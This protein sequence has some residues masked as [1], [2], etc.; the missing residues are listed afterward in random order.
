[1]ESFFKPGNMAEKEGRA[2]LARWANTLCSQGMR[3]QMIRNYPQFM[4]LLHSPIL[5]SFVLQSMCGLNRPAHSKELN[6]C[7]MDTKTIEGCLH[8]AI[9]SCH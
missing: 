2:T 3:N 9:I 8:T 6:M 4:G 7:C 5:D 1:M